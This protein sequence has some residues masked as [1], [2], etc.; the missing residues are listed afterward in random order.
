MSLRRGGGRLATRRRAHR[1]NAGSDISLTPSRFEPCGLT[2]MYAMRYGTL[3]VTRP[4]GGLAD[5]VV[6]AADAAGATGFTFAEPNAAGLLACLGRA[7]D[8]FRDKSSWRRLQHTAMARDFGWDASA[9][10]YLA[11]YRDLLPQTTR[12]TPR[13]ADAALRTA[14]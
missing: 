14:A 12:A 3:P 10:R 7:A 1:L 5:T 8:H 9:Q 2:T 4:V 11:V 13:A 6:D